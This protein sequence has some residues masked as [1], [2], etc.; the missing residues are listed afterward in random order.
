MDK[1][2]LRNITLTADEDLIQEARARAKELN[3]TLNN[4]FR[5]WL[6][7]FTRPALSEASY[8]EII[9]SLTHV[10]AGKRFDRDE[11]NER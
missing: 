5:D 11:L 10:N 6:E 1:K 8:D 2:K 4:A 7:Q 9:A 3:T